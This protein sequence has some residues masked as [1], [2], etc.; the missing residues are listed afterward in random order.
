MSSH[1]SDHL[2]RIV[3]ADGLLRGVAADTR[4]L[5]E[6]IRS[7]QQSDPTGTVALGRIA[8]GAALLGALLKQDQRLALAIEGNG[9]MQRLYAETD[10]TGHVRATAS[11][12]VA[13]LPP[14]NNCF[15]VP[16][17]VGRAGFLTVTRDLG[18]KE[19]YQG[20]V[21]LFSSEIAED[22]AYYLTTSEQ[23][24]SSVG[25]GVALDQ[26][27]AVA[28]AGGFLIQSM[29]PGDDAVL[30]QLE[31]RLRALPGSA[32][33]LLDGA[34]PLDI[35]HQIFADIPF[36][37]VAE[38]PLAFRCSCSRPQVE[39]IA[40]QLLQNEPPPDDEE[41]VVTCEFCRQG[42]SFKTS[43]LLS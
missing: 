17:A 1:P 7:R 29:P 41:L 26:H 13:G 19:P 34:S 38:T 22:L 5:V 23:I 3:S 30:E 14:L 33:L 9:T 11:V 36:D 6:E 24:P 35:L 4:N 15:D 32:Q 8:S 16:G 10:A 25:L 20:T 27:G 31:R 28:A 39:R 43:E 18:L 37:V 2:V 40:R 12:P 21:Q 42:Y